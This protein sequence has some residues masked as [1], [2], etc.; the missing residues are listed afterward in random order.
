MKAAA[1]NEYKNVDDP[2][3]AAFTYYEHPNYVGNSA[4]HGVGK[5]DCNSTT[6]PGM[7]KFG[8]L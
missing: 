2:V 1:A 5:V 4:S 6:I 3:N 8:A 7:K